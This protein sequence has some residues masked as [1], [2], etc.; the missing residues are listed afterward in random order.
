MVDE[1]TSAITKIIVTIVATL[2][3][4]VVIGLVKRR[5]LYLVVPK[6][7]SFSQLSDKG[8]FIELT[9]INRGFKTEEKIEIQLN[10]ACSYELIAST[11]GNT[12]LH[13]NKILAER[14]SGEDEITA[15]VLTEGKE[16]TR[17]DIISISSKETKGKLVKKLDDILP[18]SRLILIF[19]IITGLLFSFIFSL[20]TILE[21]G[22]KDVLIDAKQTK[23]LKNHHEAEG[24]KISKSY[25][26]NGISKYYKENELPFQVGLPMRQGD[27]VSIKINISN[28]TE[29]PLKL[30]GKMISPAGENDALRGKEWFHDVILFPSDHEGKTLVAYLP[31]K[32]KHQWLFLEF[33]IWADEGLIQFKKEVN[34]SPVTKK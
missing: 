31:M 19:I 6:L 9:L 17:E 4:S 5:R 16:F 14:L 22:K 20:P 13:K 7:F 27:T 1:P 23:S 15:I 18:S 8:K 29:K 12:V 25:Y 3:A 2:L 34:L 11:D 24:W 32:Y 21:F 33:N 28:K 30:D 26:E 10:P